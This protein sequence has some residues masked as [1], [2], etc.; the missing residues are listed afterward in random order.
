MN[1]FLSEVGR[2]LLRSFLM[3]TCIFLYYNNPEEQ[4]LLVTVAYF[5][6]QNGMEKCDIKKKK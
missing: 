2:R 1:I 5:L 4:I 6:V 3:V